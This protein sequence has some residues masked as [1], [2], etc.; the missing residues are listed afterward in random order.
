MELQDDVL[1][2]QHHLL[3]DE[4]TVV[5]LVK[6]KAEL[7]QKGLRLR[8]TEPEEGAVALQALG[9]I[10]FSDARRRRGVV[11]CGGHL[12]LRPDYLRR[13]KSLSRWL[14]SR[15]GKKHQRR[16]ELNYPGVEKYQRWCEKFEERDQKHDDTV[17]RLRKQR[18]RIQLKR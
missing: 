3:R 5:E 7:P 10:D 11:F 4:D 1:Q 2:S 18:A 16:T 9:C 6:L 17:R 15:T 13:W 8:G 12:Q 14:Q